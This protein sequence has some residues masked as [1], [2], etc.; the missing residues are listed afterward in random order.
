MARLALTDPRPSS[1]RN[2]ADSTTRAPY[3][4]AFP[5][6]ERAYWATV[7]ESQTF[8]AEDGRES[9][10]VRDRG[11]KARVTMLLHTGEWAR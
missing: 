2:T 5:S 8:R 3:S 9:Q 6:H 10:L 1:A 7:V 11:P 4:R